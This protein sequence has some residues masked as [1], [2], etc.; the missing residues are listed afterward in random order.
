VSVAT[1]TRADVEW[2]KMG[3]IDVRNELMPRVSKNEAY[4]QELV[5]VLLNGVPLPP[6]EVDRKK[7]VLFDG[8]HR[9]HAYKAYYGEKW[10]E[11]K[12]PVVWRDDLPDPD[13]ETEMFRLLALTANRANGLP[14]TR[15][16]KRVV[17]AQ[18]IRKRGLEVVQKYAALI[19][20]TPES[21]KQLVSVFDFG[22]A[23]E[24]IS[25][26]GRNNGVTSNEVARVVAAQEAIESSN[27]TH[28]GGSSIAP[29]TAVRY[30]PV[31]SPIGH[32]RGSRPIVLLACRKMREALTYVRLGELTDAE[33]NALED[34]YN[35]IGSVLY[36][37]ATRV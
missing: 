14:I 3:S 30:Y 20:E 33:R 2:V 9:F 13:D 8:H 10:E 29:S 12:V 31:G 37:E 11:S 1:A 24:R 32:R 7:N 19:N 22:D 27:G 15:S 5:K 16:D 34:V 28:E 25:P 26:S 35:R 21:L 17:I 4:I 18:V 23:L 6:L 36:A